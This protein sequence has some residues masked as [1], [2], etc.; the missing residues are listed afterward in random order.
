MWAKPAE[1]AGVS[2]TSPGEAHDRRGDALIWSDVGGKVS[3]SLRK[4]ALEP[5]CPAR[6]DEQGGDPWIGG[7]AIPKLQSQGSGPSP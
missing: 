2:H 3:C 7:M 6:D 4:D 5:L 1:S